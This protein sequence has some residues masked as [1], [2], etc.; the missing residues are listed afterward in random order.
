MYTM[1]RNME[2]EREHRAQPKLIPGGSKA[3][4]GQFIGYNL[5][6]VSNAS[7]I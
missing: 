2:R 7:L 4:I 5:I 1:L 6:A 3:L